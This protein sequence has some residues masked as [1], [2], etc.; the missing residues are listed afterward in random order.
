MIKKNHH[1]S[2]SQSEL[3]NLICNQKEILWKDSF[4]DT[5]KYACGGNSSA[6]APV[7][8]DLSLRVTEEKVSSC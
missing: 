7:T 3:L 1:F 8:P 2:V 6:W 4:H 5:F